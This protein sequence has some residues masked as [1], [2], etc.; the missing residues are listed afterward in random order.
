MVCIY[1]SPSQPPDLWRLCLEDGSFVQL[2][3]SLPAELHNT[4]FI[5]PEEVRYPSD[6]GA[7]IPA[8]LYRAPEGVSAVV[9]IH[10]GPNWLFQF[11]WHPLMSYMASRG[12][13]VL[14]P[15]YR[16]STGYG[17]KWQT[18]SRF[19]MGGV[20]ARDCA[21]AATY[22]VEIGLAGKNQV[23]VTGRS[24]GGY[25]TICC[26]TMFPEL[27]AGG[28]AVVPFLNWLSSHHLSREDLQ[29][30]NI[31]NMGDPEENRELWIEHSPYFFL[32]KINAPVQLICGA[33]DPRCPAS[34]SIAARDKLKE[35]GREVEFLLYE[36]EGHTFL[37]TDSL[38]DSEIKRVD[39]LARILQM[40]AQPQT[41][42][43]PR[44]E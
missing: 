19:D 40:N 18:A 25:L 1:E 20:D 44:E 22:L 4:R 33:N 36:D 35:L 3:N 13:T 34:D 12:W 8:L 32:D 24:H 16:G 43:H 27:W 23:A 31:E 29:H 5:Q 14:A 30:W 41:D 17:R 9:N 42:E 6:E 11:M 2:T 26:L 38:I 37:A 7:M 21:A 15:N 28:S 10:G 39:F